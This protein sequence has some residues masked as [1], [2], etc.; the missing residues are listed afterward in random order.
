MSTSTQL[1][2]DVVA[3]SFIDL[4]QAKTDS[5]NKTLIFFF[6]EDSGHS[7]AKK[8]KVGSKV[9]CANF[10]SSACCGDVSLIAVVKSHESLFPAEKEE[11]SLA[12]SLNP[13][14]FVP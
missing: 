10:L 12:D 11:E 14:M 7:C 4:I 3:L 9:N 1:V 13:I 2:L 5:E 8:Q 6:G